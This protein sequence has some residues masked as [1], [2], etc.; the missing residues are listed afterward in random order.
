MNEQFLEV[1]DRF[2][3]QRTYV[4]DRFQEQRTYVDD[5]FQEQRTY[6]DDR[7]KDLEVLIKNSRATSGWNDI[8]PVRVQNEIPSHFPNKVIKF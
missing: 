1:Y 5:R 8:Y 2:Q 7:F 3:E 6:V 4:D